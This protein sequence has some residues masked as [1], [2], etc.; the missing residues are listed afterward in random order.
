MIDI[1][2]IPLPLFYFGRVRESDLQWILAQISVLPEPLRQDTA[3]TYCS[4]FL[5]FGRTSANDWLTSLMEQHDGVVP[6]IKCSSREYTEQLLL[7]QLPARVRPA[8]IE[9]FNDILSNPK[10][11]HKAASMLRAAVKKYAGENH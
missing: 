7:S 5:K 11:A 3:D 6:L 10:R 1:L 8:A 2:D 4:Q 9:A